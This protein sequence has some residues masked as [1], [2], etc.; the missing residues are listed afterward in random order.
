[1]KN[2]KLLNLCL[3]ASFVFAFF[4]VVKAQKA[5]FYL[6]NGVSV[7]IKTQTT[8]PNE[9]TEG[10]GNIYG[11]GDSDGKIFHRIMTD[12]KN[13]IYF[14]YD[15]SVE[16]LAERG[17]Y[18]VS[19]K[20]LTKE[21]KDY[22]NNASTQ[23]YE[24]FTARNL[25]QYPSGIILSEG[26]TLTLDIL[27]NPQT[28]SKISDVIV[29]SNNGGKFGD[30]FSD[31]KPPKDFKIEDV[32]IGFKEIEIYIDGKIYKSSRI[33]MSGA[34]IW[35]YFPGKGRFIMSPF[36]QSGY[37]FQKIGVIDNKQTAFKYG[38]NDYKF[39]SKDFVMGYGGKWNLWVMFDPNYKFEKSPGGLT[40]T[41]PDNLQVGA[42]DDVKYL[43]E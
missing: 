34:V 19:I 4:G 42:V 3:V 20:P 18:T 13:K 38:G 36:E 43:F 14:G 31:S 12:L 16:P 35:V 23:K 33:G 8:P 11:G 21:P 9:T 40:F 28:K 26:D 27:E 10:Y 2:K 5:I 1:M 32:Q 15:L 25:P 22:Y 6:D 24:G 30:Y 17:K 37:D 7:A 29:I 41:T 39:V